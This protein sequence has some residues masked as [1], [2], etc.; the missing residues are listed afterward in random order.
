M[1]VFDDAWNRAELPTGAVATIG[2]YDG[3]HRG[4]RAIL[5]KVVERSRKLEVPAAVVTFEPHPAK[6]LTPEREPRCLTTPA[7]KARLLS[8]CAIDLAFV[9]HFDAEFS[10]VEAGDFV[11]QFL[12]QR[13]DLREIYVGS[14]FVFGHGREGDLALLQRLGTDTGHG[15][16]P[17]WGVKEVMSGGA[18]ISSTRIREAVS[19]GHVEVA[20]SL[21]GRPYELV[22]TVV[23]GAGTGRKL[24]FPTI[25]LD[26]DNELVPAHGV[27]VT[28]VALDEGDGRVR[29]LPSV[30]NVGVRP[31][32][33]RDS[34]TTVECH[35][36]DFSDDLYG[37]TVAIEFLE[38]LRGE[39]TFP[40][41]E[42]LRSQIQ[43]DVVAARTR[44]A[45][46]LTGTFSVG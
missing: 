2:N 9:V 24:G 44:L 17:A 23:R 39:R 32:I 26:T 46:S 15:A 45:E 41:L 21:L 31:T 20:E 14:R 27:Y 3:V 1:R 42:A 19:T 40:S 13:L 6:V 33:H 35:L 29:Y 7:Q 11:E 25:N 18:P 43:R 30:T 38:R 12:H 10:R 5:E 36:L 22:G 8:D 16:H 34:T 37:K 28:M 4:Q